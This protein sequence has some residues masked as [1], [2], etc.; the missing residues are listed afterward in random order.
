EM[1]ADYLAR[2]R[3]VQEEGPY[4]LAGWSM[5]GLVAFEMAR[6]LEAAGEVVELLALV[7]S[8]VH[9]EDA[10]PLD[11]DDPGLLASFVLHLGLAPEQIPLSAEEAA[12][13]APGE[14]LRRAWEA[15]READLVPGDL[16]L[17]RFER[18][19]S[20]FRANVAAAAAYRPEPC[21]ADLL[22][23]LAEERDTPADGEVA[24]WASLTR[25]IVRSAT[26]AGD[27]FTVVREPHVGGL[28]GVLAEALAR[29]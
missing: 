27:H 9:P 6:R 8:R 28:A 11:P 12:S 23:I 2:L 20:V 16:G 4:R 10:P 5:G 26:V 1:A 21:A 14:R 29:A 13:L 19:W 22:L 3:T 25:G 24:R 15:A 18:L 17:A 7:D